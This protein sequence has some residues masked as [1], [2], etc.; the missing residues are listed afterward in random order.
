M[1]I[2][3]KKGNKLVITDQTPGCKDLAEKVLKRQWEV[4]A[5]GKDKVKRKENLE[6]YFKLHGI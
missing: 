5:F 4:V 3:R 6:K 2:E 1:E